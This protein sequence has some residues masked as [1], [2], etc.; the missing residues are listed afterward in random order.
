MLSESTARLV[1]GAAVLGAREL[2]RVKG[3]DTP[4]PARRLLA[5]ETRHVPVGTVA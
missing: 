5:V 1:D 4:V 2:V 3:V